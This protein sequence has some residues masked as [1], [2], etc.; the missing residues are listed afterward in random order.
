MHTEVLQNQN[1]DL[2]HAEAKENENKSKK[3]RRGRKIKARPKKKKGDEL[4]E[5]DRLQ[6][7]PTEK[8]KEIN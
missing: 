5:F 2:V 7:E 3:H 1:E 8:S 6:I 4:E